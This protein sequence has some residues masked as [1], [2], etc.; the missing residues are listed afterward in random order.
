MESDRI[1]SE[2]ARHLFI[3]VVLLVVMCCCLCWKPRTDMDDPDDTDY[4]GCI[5]MGG[6]GFVVIDEECVYSTNPCDEDEVEECS[7]TRFVVFWMICVLLLFWAILGTAIAALVEAS[8]SSDPAMVHAVVAA[9]LVAAACVAAVNLNCLGWRRC[10]QLRCG[11]EMW[12][13]TPVLHEWVVCLFGLCAGALVPVL[14]WWRGTDTEFW[15]AGSGEADANVTLPAAP[16]SPPAAPPT[17][18]STDVG[19][20]VGLSIAGCAGLAAAIAFLFWLKSDDDEGNGASQTVEIRREREGNGASRTAEIPTDSV[21]LNY[22]P[23]PHVI[24]R[25]PQ[26]E[27]EEKKQER[28]AKKAA[29][30]TPSSSTPS[31]LGSSSC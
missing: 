14:V 5:Q 15:D 11:P 24:E 3:A 17:S 31:I 21:E 1:E 7:G 30:H 18:A 8:E 13:R 22:T 29:K 25:E 28:E 10:R 26:V 19:L 23:Q 6:S 27:A 2:P 4:E 20:I 9:A 12:G 16:P